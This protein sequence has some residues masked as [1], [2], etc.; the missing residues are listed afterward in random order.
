[1]VIILIFIRSPPYGISGIVIFY[2]EFVFRGTTGVDT[3]HNVDSTKFADL[4]FF[5]TFQ[6]RFG[7]FFK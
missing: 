7:L 6:I 4:S 1:M 3:C 2:D 5:K